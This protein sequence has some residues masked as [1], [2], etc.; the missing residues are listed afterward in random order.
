[1]TEI[2]NNFYD[3]C[4]QYSERDDID[5]DGVMVVLEPNTGL[6][7][8][9]LCNITPQSSILKEIC[10]MYGK[11]AGYTSCAFKDITYK[12]GQFLG[13][14][15]L[16]GPKELHDITSRFISM[17]KTFHH[18]EDSRLKTIDDSFHIARMLTYA[19]DHHGDIVVEAQPISNKQ[20]L[21]D[22]YLKEIPYDLQML[23]KWTKYICSGLA[24][25]DNAYI[26]VIDNADNTT[27]FTHTNE[28]TKARFAEIMTSDM[29]ARSK[30]LWKEC[31]LR[32]AALLKQIEKSM[33]CEDMTTDFAQGAEIRA[34]V[35]MM[36]KSE[37]ARHCKE[38]LEDQEKV[39]GKTAQ[40]LFR[41]VMES[42]K[43]K[44]QA[45]PSLYKNLI[46]YRD[47]NVDDIFFHSEIL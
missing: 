29:F 41:E 28:I 45:A 36:D 16:T 11:D 39:G 13:L 26:K 42:E 23:D 27:T 34:E 3:Y 20:D 17:K 24:Q 7:M 9:M 32:S 18:P 12:D 30:G 43:E 15:L 21:R 22:P 14:L 19:V 25:E 1:M 37:S 8:L 40:M 44:E 4:R 10:E 2:E 6:V 33:E 35:S 31:P 5:K 38:V 47:M 46:A